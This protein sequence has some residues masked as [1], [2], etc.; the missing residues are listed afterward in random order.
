MASLKTSLLCVVVALAV[1]IPVVE[2]RFPENLSDVNGGAG[3]ATCSILLGL[4][5]KLT[6]VYNETID[7]SL[8][9][10][11]LFLPAPYDLYC[12]VAVEFLGKVDR[13]ERCRRLTG[14]S[15]CFQDR[16]SSM[17]SFV[18]ITRM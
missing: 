13:A 5:D 14:F 3:C 17:R 16:S 18:V 12:K 8:E 1:F 2:G 6:I 11:C 7:R 9:R 10:L 4:V 15:D